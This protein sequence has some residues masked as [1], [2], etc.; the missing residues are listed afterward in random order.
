MAKLKDGTRVYGDAT[1]DQT[2]TVGNISITGNL[3][4]QGSTT[5]IDS[6]VTRVEDPI[7]ELGGGANGAALTNNDA[8]ERGILMH[9]FDGGAV[10]AFMGWHTSNG[11]FEFG[12]VATESSGNITV[13]THGNLCRHNPKVGREKGRDDGIPKGRKRKGCCPLNIS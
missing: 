7:F 3:I 5:S 9:Y 11:Q 13:G 2:L 1:V 10:D 12:S 4:V 8:K 6:T